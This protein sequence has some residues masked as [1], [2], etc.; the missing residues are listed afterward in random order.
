VQ[1]NSSDMPMAVLMVNVA[2]HVS[3]VAY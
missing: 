3:P 1:A 2:D